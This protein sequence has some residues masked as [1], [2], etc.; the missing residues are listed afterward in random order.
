MQD[1]EEHYASSAEPWTLPDP[2]V[3]AEAEGLSPGRALDLGCGEGG[4][5]IWLAERGWH[6]T[7]VDSAPTAIARLERCALDRSLPHVQGL[8]ADI[9]E[10]P[11]GAEFNLVLLCYMHLRSEARA[12]LLDRGTAAL[13]PGGTLLYVAVTRPDT[14]GA[15]VCSD[16]VLAT[17]ARIVMALV[18]LQIEKANVA[19]RPLSVPGE[20]F[21]ADVMTIRASRAN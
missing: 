15:V 11:F 3:V 13:A 1:W 16:E 2:A 17:P 19:R 14:E 12:R 10:H 20:T 6:V 9:L 7:A 21:E 4:N 5:A 18:G 8:V